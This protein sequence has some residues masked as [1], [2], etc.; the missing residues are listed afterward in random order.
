MAVLE[1]SCTSLLTGV[2][3]MQAFDKL[4]TNI[5]KWRRVLTA[6]RESGQGM[7]EYALTM[8]AVAAVCIVAIDR[9]NNAVGG[10]LARVAASLS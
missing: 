4:K 8:A 3:G 9:L 6:K 7:L 2:I 10:L 5:R 1:H